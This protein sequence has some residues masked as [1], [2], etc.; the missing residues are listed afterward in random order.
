MEAVLKGNYVGYGEIAQKLESVFCIRTGKR[1]GFA[2]ASG[3]HALSLGIRALDLPKCS[4]VSLPVLTCPSLIDAVEGAGHRPGLGDI[5]REDLTL[6]ASSLSAGTQAIIAP[7]AYGAPLDIDAIEQLGLPWI[8]DCATSPATYAK[9]RPAGSW[10][11]LAVFSFNSTKYITAGTGGMLLTND[12]DLADK[13]HGLLDSDSSSQVGA[14]QNGRPS[15]FPGRLSDVNAAIALEQFK[16]MPSFLQRRRS[17][18]AIYSQELCDVPGLSVPANIAGHSY[19]RYIVRTRDSSG[20][21]AA[22]LQSKGI[23]ARSAVNPWLDALVGH[24]SARGSLRNAG[25]WRAHLLSLPI[26]ASMTDEEA[27]YVAD[28]LSKLLRPS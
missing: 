20:N 3:F 21:I 14:W 1:F 10:G 6:E 27:Y 15:G 26:N 7:H 9:A 12:P 11:T 8:E 19:Y 17:I 18:A 28:N 2:V 13:I 25:Y 16:K 22:L 5:S 4:L 24:E 23:D